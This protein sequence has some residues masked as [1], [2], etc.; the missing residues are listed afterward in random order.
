MIEIDNQELER[1]AEITVKCGGVQ[2]MHKP[3]YT[4][5]VRY[6]A[7]RAIAAFKQYDYLLTR[8]DDASTLI[9]EVQEAIVHI[10]ALSRYFWPS[11]SGSNKNKQQ[12]ALKEE[13]GKR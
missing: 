7:D 4:Y 5:S 12:R 8:T 10:G 2:P 1:R 13:R 9:S 3:F 11:P 6:S